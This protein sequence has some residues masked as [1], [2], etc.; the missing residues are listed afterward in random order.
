MN[1]L[2]AEK[3][4]LMDLLKNVDFA[5]TA[6]NN[7][8]EARKNVVILSLENSQLEENYVK[9]LGKVVFENI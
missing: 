3:H 7:L 6:L 5:Q 2:K 1:F 4:R 8:E 9:T